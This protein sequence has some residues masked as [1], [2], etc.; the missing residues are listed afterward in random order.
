MGTWRVFL[1][2]LGNLYLRLD[3]LPQRY[4]EYVEISIQ[5]SF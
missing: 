3:E 2:K 4:A 5:L 1:K